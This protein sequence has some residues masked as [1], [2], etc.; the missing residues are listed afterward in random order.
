MANSGPNQNGSQ[1]FITYQK[2][3]HLNNVYTVFGKVIDGWETLDLIEKEPVDA[4]DR[5]LNDITIYTIT[6]HANPIAENE[7]M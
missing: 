1:F 2:Q 7:Q 4:K 6:I 3:T 5:P